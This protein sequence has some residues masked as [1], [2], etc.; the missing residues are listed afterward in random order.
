MIG[1]VR[2]DP[3]SPTVKTPRQDERRGV[4]ILSKLNSGILEMPSHRKR[5][6]EAVTASTAIVLP[7]VKNSNTSRDLDAPRQSSEADNG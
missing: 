7:H 5:L 4:R 3:R 6:I 2:F 1:R